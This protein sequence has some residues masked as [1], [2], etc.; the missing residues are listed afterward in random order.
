MLN[1]QEKQGS[2]KIEYLLTFIRQ[3]VKCLLS[4][5]AH[6]LLFE[7]SEMFAKLALSAV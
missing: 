6:Q 1:C 2:F 5:S 3:A 4:F 7:L